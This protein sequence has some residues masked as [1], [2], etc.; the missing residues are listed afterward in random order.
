[1]AENLWKG[2]DGTLLSG[3]GDWEVVLAT[4]GAH[5]CTL[6]PPLPCGAF[7]T[8]CRHQH[9]PGSGPGRCC[10]RVLST[11]FSLISHTAAAFWFPAFFPQKRA[12]AMP[13]S[14][15][16]LRVPALVPWEQGLP[17][18]L[19]KPWARQRPR[20]GAAVSALAGA[21]ASRW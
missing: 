21:Q 17:P 20:V 4:L 9:P 10:V 5:T 13:R 11:L 3:F 15:R 16:D 19:I 18:L 12:E 7:P 8:I 6:L 14:S 1:M 2:E